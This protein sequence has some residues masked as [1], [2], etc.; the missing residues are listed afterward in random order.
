M[1]M[2]W[3]LKAM[4]IAF[5]ALTAFAIIASA[6]AAQPT[7][8]ET[9]DARARAE[10]NR[11][12]MQDLMDQVQ[13]DAAARA[14]ARPPVD[15]AV[16]KQRA[17][18]VARKQEADWQAKLE[19]ARPFLRSWG[20]PGDAETQTAREEART[21]L[22]DL[23]LKAAAAKTDA[24]RVDAAL[25][26]LAR[27]L[28]VARVRVGNDGSK[29][30]LVGAVGG[31]PIYYSSQNLVAAASISADEL[32]PTN[33]SIPWPHA[34]TGR[35]LTGSNVTLGM[36]EV[37]GGVWTNHLELTNRVLQVDN[38]TSTPVTQDGH[39]TAVAG[40]MAA[41]GNLQ[42]NVG[43]LTTGWMRGV[44]Y[45]ATV[46]AYTL[47]GFKE[48]TLAAAG[49]T[50]TGQ[51]LRFS[52]HSYGAAGGWIQQTIQVVQGGQTNTINNAW[53]WRGSISLAEEW[54]F[55][56]YTPDADD[57]SGCTDID[58]FLSQDAPR[59]LMVYAAGNDR[60]NGPGGPTT[61]YYKSGTNQY[62]WSGVTNPPSN[63]RIWRNGDGTNGG[64]DTLLAPGTSKNV[65]TVGAVRDVYKF[66][67]NQLI[68]GFATG[69]SNVLAPFSGCGPTDD[70]RIKPEVVAV[71][72][73]NPTLRN[74]GLYTPA[75]NSIDSY[76]TAQAGTSFSAPAVTGGLG[77]AAQ[78]RA[79]L[80]PNL[81]PALD[82][83]R[84]ST[85]RGLAIHTADDVDGAGPDYQMGYG[86]FNAASA[87]AQVE[88]DQQH[89]RG[90]HIKEFQIGVSN[91]VAW[92]IDVDSVPLKVTATWSDPAGPATNVVVVDPTTPMLVN[93]LDLRVERVGATN[94]YYPWILNPDLTNKSETARA[95]AATTGVD[96][97]NNVEQVSITNPTSGR[98]RI[99]VKHSGGLPGG[100]APSAQWV[101]VLTSGDTPV[102]PVIT[103]FEPNPQRTQMLLTYTADP[104]A[105]FYLL[106][107]SSLLAS[108]QTAWLTN[109]TLKADGVTNSVMVTN[110]GQSKLFWSL[111][112]QQ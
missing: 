84:G 39:A 104:G 68:M 16:A 81:D 82:A 38:S 57:G 89:G 108:N 95:A 19:A 21:E 102:S 45:Q 48:E 65:L 94:V 90:T 43:G 59:H 26:E 85:W 61:Y 32:W 14:A 5:R 29:G 88:R 2:R 28:G 101:S 96:N 77:L 23:A 52:N 87:V 110:S 1:M 34:S 31:E 13:A 36:W 24:P 69:S 10:A 99:V 100:P 50:V 111:R 8:E 93:N 51:P 76:F 75:T 80:F 79:Q 20:W 107:A 63:S 106:S 58:R 64:Y 35:N 33:S 3:N 40:T 4:G 55:G 56:F 92:E 9:A 71:G 66:V 105:Y 6:T 41:G 67:G 91:S 30:V 53:I 103:S 73:A 74:F 7:P 78:R 60:L 25:D 12:Y 27:K 98:Y 42:F 70:G 97:R 15:P 109:A 54:K 72:Q 62:D 37:N 17:D 11:Q 49:G 18:E 83:W 22:Q 46:N 112:R 44:A 86:L 47:A